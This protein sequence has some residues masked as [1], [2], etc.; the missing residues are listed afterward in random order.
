[1]YRKSSLTAGSP[2]S[3]YSWVIS[4]Q[5]WGLYKHSDALP[6]EGSTT[7]PGGSRFL[8]EMGTNLKNYMKWILYC[9]TCI[10][11][12]KIY[13]GVHKT[14]NPEVF[15]GYIG[16]GIRINSPSSY[17]NPTTP[18]QAAVKKYGTAKFKRQVVKIFD[19][20]EAAYQMEAQIVDDAFIKRHDTYNAHIGGC[21]GS[22][23]FRKVYQYNMN[24]MYQREWDTLL[25]AS[26]FYEV[27]D[28]AIRNSCDLGYCCKG[29]YWSFEKLKSIDVSNKIVNKGTPCYKYDATTLKFIEGYDTFSIAANANGIRLMV[30]ERAVKGGYKCG[31]YFYSSVLMDEFIPHAKVTLK[32]KSLYIYSL[33]GEYITTLNSPSEICEFFKIKSTNPVTVA[34][35]TGRQYKDFQ[36]SFEKVDRLPPMINKRNINKRIG[37]YTMDGVLI[38]EWDSITAAQNEYGKG[39]SKVLRGQQSH[40][41]HFLWKY[42]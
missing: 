2:F 42:L 40:C 1:M 41:K 30:L 5:A 34:I 16:C 10:V 7:I 9:T 21:G 20:A 23:Y 33:E 15:D 37:Q 28:T 27:S 6:Q 26:D 3:W 18:L 38:K 11:N 32:G 35:R 39:I 24:G 13:Y 22:S 17:M 25:E 4:N 12:N 29:F 14:E 8:I 31:N 19:N 36:F